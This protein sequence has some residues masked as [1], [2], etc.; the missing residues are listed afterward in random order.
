MTTRSLLFVVSPFALVSAAIAPAK[1]Q[2]ASGSD[3]ALKAY[4]SRLG[5]RD[6]DPNDIRVIETRRIESRIESRLDSRLNTRLNRFV[7]PSTDDK[8]TYTP[9]VD[10][11]TKTD[12]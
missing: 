12:R 11:G 2:T 6:Q 10:D 1:A 7:A 5:D 9:K 8:S 4:G 3:R